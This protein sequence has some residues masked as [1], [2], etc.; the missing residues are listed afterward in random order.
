MLGSPRVIINALG[1]VTSRRDFMP[2]GEQVFSDPTYRP[3]NLKY[4]TG[5][6]IRQK[7]TGYQK[8][9]ETQLDFAE[10]RMYQN[11]HARFTAVDPLLASGK[12]VNPQTFNRYVYVLNNPLIFTD[13]D[14]LQVAVATGPVYQSGN[15]FRIYRNPNKVPGN[16]SRV[17]TTIRAQ[18]TLNRTLHH[19]TVTPNGWRVG[20]RVD[21][22]K[23]STPPATP[24]QT[25]S[26]IS[27]MSQEVVNGVRDGF[28]GIAKGVGNA[29]AVALNSIT[30]DLANSLG[31]RFLFGGS[32][33]VEISLPFAYNNPREGSYGSAGSTG[34]LA[35]LGVAGGTIFGGSSTL[36]V[37]PEAVTPRFLFHYT[38][39]QRAALIEESG[40]LGLVNRPVFTT[41]ARNLTPLQAQVELALP[42]SNTATAVFRI[43]TAQINFSPFRVGRV[44]GNVCNRAGGGCEFV[45]SQPIP[46]GAFTRIQ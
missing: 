17:E 27:V 6:E 37:V 33:P 15:T 36:S 30:N 4:N 32:N 18:T 28:G 16:Y 41:N 46:G 42:Q 29:P 14:G 23:F 44:T 25:R 21:N 24:V 34:T 38:S 2:F 7:F 45:F 8:D 39:P 26:D 9:E 1:D 22:Q 35:G 12:S 43:D 11:K 20:D 19:L 40:Q 31:G 3:T 13:P 10:A 5:D